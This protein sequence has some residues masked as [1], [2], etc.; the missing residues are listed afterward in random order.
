MDHGTINTNFDREFSSGLTYANQYLIIFILLTTLGT[1][2][3][4]WETKEFKDIAKLKEDAK[5]KEEARKKL[6]KIIFKCM[7]LPQYIFLIVALLP[8][9]LVS[10]TFF[11]MGFTAFADVKVVLVIL[12]ISLLAASV[13]YIFSKGTFKSVLLSIDNTRRIRK[14]YNI[15]LATMLILQITSLLCVCVIYTFLLSYSNSME[16]KSRVLKEHYTYEVNWIVEHG[17]PKNKEELIELINGMDLISKNDSV[18]LINSNNEFVNFNNNEVSEFFIKYALEL[19][20]AADNGV[21]DY[22]GTET[23]GVVIPLNING[24]NLKVVVKYDLTNNLLG[25]TFSNLVIILLYCGVSIF[26]FATS[27]TQ[28]ISTVAKSLKNIADNSKGGIHKKL[29]V[30]SNDEIGELVSSFN[31]IQDLATEYLAQIE[32]SQTIILEQERLASLGQMIGGIAHNMKTPIMSVAGAAEGLT[33][34]V[35]E[36]LAS[37]S[38][39]QVTPEDHKEIAKDMLEWITKIKTHTSY[40][41]DIITT[42]KGQASQLSTSEYAEFTVYDLAKKVDILVKHEIKK[43][44]LILETNIKCDPALVLHGD[45]NSLIQVIINL[46]S[47]SVQSYNGK[48]HEKIEFTIDADKKNVSIFVI[49]HGCGMTNETQ[50]K[51]FKSMITTK[52]KNGTGLGLYI[53]YSTI[54]GKFGGNIVFA[55]EVNKGTT[56]KITIPINYKPMKEE[57]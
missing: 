37:I 52:G 39:P 56:F 57:E 36:Y 34:L 29:A 8:T 48:P 33:E 51:L 23:Q 45:I 24:R 3:I 12:T 35:G 11:F 46:I 22:Y 14:K 47:N 10:I 6:D 7:T 38:N 17:N 43:A 9:L 21:Y 4:L 54:K 44:L 50:K 32:N 19:S 1:I 53:S 27:M 41:S 26:F 49:D 28:E 25:S 55:S 31:D 42:V 15:S 5:L 16:D 2:F 20:A 40:M 13:A 30:T 18:F